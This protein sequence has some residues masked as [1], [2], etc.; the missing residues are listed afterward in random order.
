MGMNVSGHAAGEL[1]PYLI[2]FFMN[3]YVEIVGL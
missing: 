2:R 3:N 1:K